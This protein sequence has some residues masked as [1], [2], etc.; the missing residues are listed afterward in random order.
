[1]CIR[2]RDRDWLWEDW[3]DALAERE[4]DACRWTACFDCGVCPQLDTAIQ[5]GPTGRTLLP[6][7]VAPSQGPGADPGPSR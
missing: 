5:I 1:M 7:T 3:Q 6:V 2:D 4:V